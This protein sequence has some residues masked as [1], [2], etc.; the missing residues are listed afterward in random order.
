[1]EIESVVERPLRCDGTLRGIG[2]DSARPR[3]RF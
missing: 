3:C 2:T 1:M